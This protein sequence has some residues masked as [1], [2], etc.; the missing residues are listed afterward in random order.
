MIA[1]LRPRCRSL[2]PQK[3]TGSQNSEQL[4]MDYF[5]KNKRQENL[6]FEDSS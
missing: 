1:L 3:E 6:S 5:N 4:R 2:L